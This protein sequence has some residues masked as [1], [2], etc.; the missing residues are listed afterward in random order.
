MTNNNSEKRHD[1]KIHMKGGEAQ[2]IQML[3]RQKILQRCSSTW[4]LQ[5]GGAR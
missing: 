1:L 4:I 3:Y 5:V 2:K